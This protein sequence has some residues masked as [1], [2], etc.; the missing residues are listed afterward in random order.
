MLDEGLESP[1]NVHVTRSASKSIAMESEDH[2]QC[3]ESK[4][5]WTGFRQK[6][7]DGKIQASVT[8]LDFY[9]PHY[10][11]ETMENDLC[12]DIRYTTLTSREKLMDA[13]LDPVKVRFRA[14]KN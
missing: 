1:E 2:Q 14:S 5:G 10:N 12:S 13:E 7:Y 11:E 9:P 3:T 8:A 6:K 4:P